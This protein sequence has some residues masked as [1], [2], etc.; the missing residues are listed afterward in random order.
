VQLRAHLLVHCWPKMERAWGGGGCLAGGGDSLGP[1]PPDRPAT[2][3]EGEAGG[4]GVRACT[5]PSQPLSTPGEGEAGRRG[6]EYALVVALTVCVAGCRPC[7]CLPRPV[8][9]G[10]CSEPRR[11]QGETPRYWRRGPHTMVVSSEL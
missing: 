6:G 3:V 8:W 11:C 5:A 10:G 1:V 9:G 7:C 2:P 4:Q